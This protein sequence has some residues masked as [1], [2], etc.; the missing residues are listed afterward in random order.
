MKLKN[1]KL[2]SLA[3]ANSLRRKLKLKRKK[4]VL[5]N[6]V[7][8]LLHPGH[9]SYLQKAGQLGELFIALNSDKSVKALKGKHRPILGEKERAYALAQMQSVTAI[10]IFRQN[11]S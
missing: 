10:L 5:T 9:L 1:P 11:Y 8:D 7:F 4:V 6:G 3:G 2:L